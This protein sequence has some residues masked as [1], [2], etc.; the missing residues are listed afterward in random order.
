[1]WAAC[2]G[3]GHAGPEWPPALAE[4]LGPPGCPPAGSGHGAGHQAGQAFV[5]SRLCS[6]G[7]ATGGKQ[8]GACLGASLPELSHDSVV[9][10]VQPLSRVSLSVTPGTAARQASLS[11]T[12]SQS[13]LT[14]TSIESVTPS[15]HL[16]LC[17]PLLLL[18]P[19]FPS[20]RSFQISQFFPSGGQSI[21]APAS[22]PVLPTN[23]QG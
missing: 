11:F 2:P 10:T 21:G 14:L 9:G 5:L 15:N 19:I 7:G 8:E 16:F 1:M 22:A 17:R 23:V 3:R 6:A 18:P 13:L 20:I 4:H 12:M